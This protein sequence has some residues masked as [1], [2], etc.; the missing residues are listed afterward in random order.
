MLQ[1][2]TVYDMVERADVAVVN[3]NLDTE[4]DS[5]SGDFKDSDI[6]LKFGLSSIF[7]NAQSQT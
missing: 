5:S 4:N 2:D 7:H 6:P 3:S 1:G